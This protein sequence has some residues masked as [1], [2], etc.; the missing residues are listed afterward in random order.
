MKD[1]W[2]KKQLVGEVMFTREQ[3]TNCRTSVF[4][5]FKIK[6]SYFTQDP[7]AG[8]YAMKVDAEFFRFKW[9]ERQYKFNPKYL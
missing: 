4:E 1:I 6:L 3:A 2:Q 8:W 7:L 9:C 5:L